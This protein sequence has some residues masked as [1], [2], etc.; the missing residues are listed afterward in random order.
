[1]VKIGDKIKHNPYGKGTIINKDL[2]CFAT[3][4]C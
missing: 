2:E 4:L 3:N 1:M